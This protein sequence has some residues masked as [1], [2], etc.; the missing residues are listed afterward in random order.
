MRRCATVLLACAITFSILATLPIS[1]SDF[2]AFAAT[3]ASTSDSRPFQACSQERAS[4]GDCTPTDDGRSFRYIY[5]SDLAFESGGSITL[6]MGTKKRLAL[7]C[8]AGAMRWASSNSRVANVSQKGRV[9]AKRAGTALITATCLDDGR[10]IACMVKV[11]RTR[12]QAQ[13]RRA[14]SA[15]RPTYRHGKRWTNG[16]YYFWSAANCHCYGCAAFAGLASDTAFGA[17]APIK[18]HAKFALIKVG[19]HVRIGNGHSVVVLRKRK[20]SI[21]V[22]EGNYHGALN[23]G[24]VIPYATLRREGFYVDTRY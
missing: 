23:W 7:T 10:S 6:P 18:R 21:V 14:I 2:A 5:Y 12:S 24:R 8:R 3:Q 4:Q 1:R 20:K 22:A 11:Y 13:A 15:L 9:S 19:D 17:Y 16:N